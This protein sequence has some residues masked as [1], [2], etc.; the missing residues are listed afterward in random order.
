M[1]LNVDHYLAALRGEVPLQALARHAATH[2]G[3]VCPLCASE[4]ERGPSVPFAASGD[5]PADVDPVADPRF[6]TG[7][8][9]E[10]AKER[11]SVLRAVSTEA[12]QDLRRL[13][14]LPPEAWHDR[15]AASRTRMRSRTF[16]ELLVAESRSRVRAEPRAAAA[17][18]ALV[19]QALSWTEGRDDLPWL[20]SLLTR[21]AAHRANALRVAGD[22]PA[23]E[24]AFR[25]L[26][27]STGASPRLEPA[28][29]AEVASLEAS[30]RIG[31]RRFDAAAECLRTAVAAYRR[32]D[33]PSGVARALIKQANLA[34][35]AGPPEEVVPTFERAARELGPAADP[36][37]LAATV[38]G[39]VNALCDLDRAT[40]ADSLLRSHRDLYLARGDEHLVANYTLLAGRVALGTGRLEVAEAH[41]A[42]ARDRLL[43]LDR[44][45]DA[46]LTSLYLADALLAA[47]KTSD[48]KRLAA[49]LVPLFRARDVARESLAALR[50]L[51]QAAKTERVTVAVLSE[52]RDRLQARPRG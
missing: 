35:A 6:L 31:Q 15:V 20:V 42:D 16:A 32:A 19:P 9:V 13:L 12:R 3:E 11:L 49:D 29:I 17:L 40:E 26:S 30:L 37:L 1:H 14:R 43:A 8:S 21:A 22:L 36:Y 48:L 38:T 28:V 47:G 33:D 51:A 25:R 45:Y 5:E 7:R 52:V 2:L 41:L 46:I 34:R 27:A 44:D 24:D 50:L 10:A 39:R 18:A 4:A 23:A